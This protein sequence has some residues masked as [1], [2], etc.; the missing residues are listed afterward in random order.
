MPVH[1]T[2]L[3]ELRGVLGLGGGGGAHVEVCWGG[4]RDPRTRVCVCVWGG[5]AHVEVCQESRRDTGGRVGGGAHVEVCQGSSK[6][7]GVAVGGHM[8]KEAGGILGVGA[9]VEV[10]QGSSK[11]MGGGGYTCWSMPGKQ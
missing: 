10:C 2:L 6:D 5:G 9:H 3:V 8:L 1:C 11:D 7:S 4:R